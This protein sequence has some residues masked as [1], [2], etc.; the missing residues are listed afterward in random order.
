ML[1]GILKKFCNNTSTKSFLDPNIARS[2]N[3]M[4]KGYSCIGIALLP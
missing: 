3:G 2:G 1:I 4:I